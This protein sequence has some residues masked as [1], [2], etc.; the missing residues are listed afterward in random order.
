M[1]TTVFFGYKTW[2]GGE[3]VRGFSLVIRRGFYSKTMPK[4]RSKSRYL[5]FF[6]KRKP[7]FIT[8]LHETDLYICGKLYWK[9]NLLPYIRINKVSEE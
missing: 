4:S 8:K 7:H 2:L 6:V 3:G 5:G 9:D 1:K